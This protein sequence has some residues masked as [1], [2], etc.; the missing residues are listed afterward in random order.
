MSL[1]PAES[2]LLLVL[3]VAAILVRLPFL[4]LGFGIDADAPRNILVAQR[5]KMEG[6]Y[7]F[8]RPPGYPVHEFLL[9][10]LP[11][12]DSPVVANGLS[13]L[14][15]AACGALIFLIV[16]TMDQRAAAVAAVT[17][18]FLPISNIVGTEAMDYSLSLALFLGFMCLWLVGHHRSAAIVLGLAAASRLTYAAAVPILV[19]P[20]ARDRG[21]T[22]LLAL[23]L[24]F[25]ASFSVF[26]LPVLLAYGPS[27]FTFYDH[28]TR[29]PVMTVIF[30][31][32][33]GIWGTLGTVAFFLVLANMSFTAFR[34]RSAVL[35][36]R[37]LAFGFITLIACAIYARLPHEV[38]Y[39]LPA[40]AAFLICASVLADRRLLV[41]LMVSVIFSNFVSIGRSGANPGPFFKYLQ[42]RENLAGTIQ[43]AAEELR[44]LPEGAIVRADS[45][46]AQAF[47]MQAIYTRRADIGIR[48]PDRWNDDTGSALVFQQTGSIYSASEGRCSVTF[49]PFV[50]RSAD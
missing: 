10:A 18:M 7:E 3:F 4:E 17:F 12:S 24:L 44:R 20:A 15:L 37:I 39:L 49:E 25:L 14:F 19:A 46:M 32:S 43:C 36:P 50:A 45:S 13:L 30:V 48:T 34:K 33:V 41:L 47:F 23:L 31:G 1:K 11:G 28:E 35:E 42:S 8:S 16:R 5:L 9:A 29:P 27:F 22:R 6:V 38:A 40:A 26:F 21:V 2:L